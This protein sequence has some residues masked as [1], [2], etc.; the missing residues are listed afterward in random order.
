MSE[1]LVVDERFFEGG[2]R[3]HVKVVGRLVH[4]KEVVFLQQEF[5]QAPHLALAR[6]RTGFWESLVATCSLRKL[7][8]AERL[9][10]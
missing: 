5:Q 8:T 2:L 1:A 6:R 3:F 4:Q 9:H 10:E 7:E